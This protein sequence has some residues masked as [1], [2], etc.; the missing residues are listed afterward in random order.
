MEREPRLSR[1]ELTRLFAVGGSTALF[2]GCGATLP[3]PAP[4]PRTP[5]DPDEAYWEKV[6]AQFVMPPDLAVMN[7]ANLCPAPHDVIET[8]YRFTR[9]IDGDPSPQNRGKFGTGREE[10]RRLL[11]EYLRASPEE[12]VITRNTSEGNNIVSSGIDLGEGDEVVIF[13]GNHPSNN[14]AWKDKGKRF[15]FKVVEVAGVS[16][17]PGEDYYVEAF[18]NAITSRTKVLSFTHVSN[19]TGDVF[20]AKA[21]CRM[22]R[23]RGV[24]TLVDGAQSFGVMDLDMSDMQPDFFTGSGH[25]WPCGPKESGV[26]YV[27]SSALDKISPSIISLIGGRTPASRK[28]ESMGQRDDPGIMAFGETIRFH[29]NIGRRAVEDRARQL[30]QALMKGLQRIDGITLKT[31]PDPRHSVSVVVFGTGS[32]NGSRLNQALYENERIAGSPRGD[33]LR[34]SLHMYNLLE[35]VERAVTAIESYMAK[36]F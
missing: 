36:G 32:L 17:H 28:L 19:T 24:L 10:T 6:K 5:A 15:G 23:E 26:L 30:G 16:P 12:I 20:P 27:R 34:L 3:R 25:K 2:V 33:G 9:D 18:S 11:A 14:K 4:L 7:A 31:D 1:R 8:M 21:I 35:D 22:A 13:N 29:M